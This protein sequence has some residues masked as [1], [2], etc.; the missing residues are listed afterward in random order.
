MSSL[1]GELIAK[2][3]SFPEIKAG[4]ACLED[5]LKAP[6]YEAVPNG[7]WSISLS[8][9]ELVTEWPSDA[10]SVIVLGLHHPED[11][12]RLDW[13]DGSNTMGNRQLMKI[14]DFL[15]QWLK[16]EHGLRA[17]PL[18]YNIERGG[19]FLK[20]AAVLAGLGVVGRNNLLLNPEW[21]PRI[22][23][24]SILIEGELEP[25]R[26]VGGFSPCDSCGKICHSVCPQDVFSTGIYY[27]PNCIAQLNADTGN[28]TSDGEV[29]EGEIPNLLIKFCRACEFACP[30]GVY[31]DAE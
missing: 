6:S 30:V 21:G 19:L 16:E 3:E 15:K 10:K 29:G 13:W 11:N 20:D 1:S 26:P 27:R 12:P 5:I 18:P 4:I 2:A 22:R 28:K 7:E 9:E 25:T 17:F 31:P 24:R 8:N 23:F 14:S